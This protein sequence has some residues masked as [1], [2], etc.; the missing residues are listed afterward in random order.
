MTFRHSQECWNVIRTLRLC[1]TLRSILSRGGRV[2]R[3]FQIRSD[4]VSPYAYAFLY[5]H[6]CH[7]PTSSPRIGM[8]GGKI[9]EGFVSPAVRS[10][11]S[12]GRGAAKEDSCADRTVVRGE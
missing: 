3:G 2:N 5:S 9:A 7:F 12:S 4:R 1:S 10:T 6:I 11:G 8:R